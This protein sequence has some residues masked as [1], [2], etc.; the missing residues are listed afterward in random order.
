MER[1][2]VT[3]QRSASPALGAALLVVAL[4]ALGACA[5]KDGS[6]ANDPTGPTA[7]KEDAAQGSP[8]D[9]EKSLER[10]KALYEKAAQ[11]EAKPDDTEQVKSLRA[12]IVEDNTHMVMVDCKAHPA[13]FA[14][15]LEAATSVEQMERDCL[16]PLDDEGTVEGKAFGGE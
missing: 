16:I 4:V 14:P 13:R 7:G 12:E 2:R 6:K 1:N 11:A 8:A 3:H 9:C 15:C 10:V 5:C